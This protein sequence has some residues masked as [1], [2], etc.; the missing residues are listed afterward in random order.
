VRHLVQAEV[1]AEFGE[2][3]EHLDDAP[4]I[5]LEKG[6]ERQQGEMLVLS[7]VLARELRGVGGQGFLGEAQGLPRDGT[8]RFGHRSR[9]C[10]H[11]TWLEARSCKKDSGFQRSNTGSDPVGTADEIDHESTAVLVPFRGHHQA[12]VVTRRTCGPY[13]N[14][15]H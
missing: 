3:D 15:G 9:C 12:A 11:S 6:L 13:R 2:I 14:S 5:G 8:W 4:V 10:S 7:E 1:G